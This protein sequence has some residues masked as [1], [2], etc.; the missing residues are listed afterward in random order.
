MNQKKMN[1]IGIVGSV[2]VALSVFLPYVSAS[3][4]GE[5]ASTS[6][7]AEVAPMA[8]V[9]IVIGA[10]GVVFSLLRVNVGLLIMGIISFLFY[11]FEEAAIQEG[12][13]ELGGFSSLVK[14]GIGYYAILIGAVVMIVA[15]IIDMNKKKKEQSVPPMNMNMPY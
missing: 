7:M 3:A 8:F 1:I 14:R 9:I 5:S 10:L 13:K 2:L 12:M 11:I 4:F 6:I 15:A